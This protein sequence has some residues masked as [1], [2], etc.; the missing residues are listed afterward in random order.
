MT[1]PLS[2]GLVGAGWIG[3]FHAATLAERL[4]GVRLAAVADPVPDAA[5][6]LK[7]PK[8]YSDPLE[9]V[10]DPAIDAVAICSPAATHADLVVAAAQ[11]GKHVFC[12]KPMALTLADA[13]RAIEAALA[14]GVA[15]QV[16]FNRRFAEDF[17]KCAFGS[18]TVRS[19]R[20][21][22]YGR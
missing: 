4:P 19:A 20:H 3:S 10:A 6:R 9:L 11:A 13:D 15:L 14:A 8:A 7:A 17:A 16:G 21:N 18:A 12:E 2:F 22:Y 1:T 5:V